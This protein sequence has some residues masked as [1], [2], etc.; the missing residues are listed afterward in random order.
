M[1][2]LTR[3]IMKYIVKNSKKTEHT[4]QGIIGTH[5]PVFWDMTDKEFQ[6]TFSIKIRNISNTIQDLKNEFED[7]LGCHD[8][9]P[10]I[11]NDFLNFVRDKEKGER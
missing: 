1:M 11:L 3:D 9:I 6:T 5:C 8:D 7:N 10:E 2:S 4:G